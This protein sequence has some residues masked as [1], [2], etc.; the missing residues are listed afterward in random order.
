MMVE[1]REARTR[2]F[3]QLRKRDRDLNAL[4]AQPNCLDDHE[5]V[6]CETVD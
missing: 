1:V 3:A 4:P 6:Y 2:V 5:E